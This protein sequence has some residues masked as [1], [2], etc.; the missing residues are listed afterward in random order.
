MSTNAAQ[1]KF[2]TDNLTQVVRTPVSGVT[3]V[4]GQSEKGAFAT[5]DSIINTWPQFLEE[6]GGLLSSSV[7]PLLVKRMLE[8]GAP[9][10]F[11]RVGHYTDVTDNTT[12]TA[13]L[14][15]ADDDAVDGV[16]ELFELIPKNPGSWENG[17]VVNLSVASNGNA[18]YFDLSISHSDDTSVSEVY[19]NLII[20]GLPDAGTSD[21]LSDIVQY[22]KYFNVTYKDLSGFTSPLVPDPLEITY[23][24]GAIDPSVIVDTDYIGDSAA[25]NGFHAFDNYDDAMQI[26][27]ADSITDTVHK[28]GSDYAKSRKDIFY[29]MHLSNLI[30]SKTAIIAKRDALVIDTKFTAIYAGGLQVVN[31]TNNQKIDIEAIT[32][33]CALAANSDNEFGEWYSFAG[34]NR[35]VIDN[36]LAVINN[37]GSPAKAADLNNLAN[38]QINMIINRNNGIKLWGNFTAQLKQDQE[39]QL[40]IARLVVF[41]QKSLK[42]VLEGYLEEPNDIPTWKRIYYTV[43]PFLDSMVT[44]RALFSYQWQG[45][46]D[47]NSLDNLITNNA[48]DVGQGKYLVK[49][50]IKPIASI[51]EITVV[52]TLTPT[53]VDFETLT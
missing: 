53:A 48:T 14:A 36:T 11:S 42:P 33:I 30:T 13:V 18:S 32:D 4:M 2:K 46:Q 9:I 21:Y 20:T 31:P 15:T 52:I 25:L 51:Q 49:F 6:Y 50:L 17:L 5:P 35:G 29:F 10:R 40:S 26:I 23:S 39:S 44:S 12:L 34:S 27:V 22:S 45:D 38:R 47:V 8:K 1:V 41:L 16:D 7:A 19:K 37:F 28:G 24:G 3:F 43:K